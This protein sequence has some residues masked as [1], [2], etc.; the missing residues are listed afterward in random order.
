[1]GGDTFRRARRGEVL[2][3]WVGARGDP[4]RAGGS[5]VSAAGEAIVGPWEEFCAPPT[6]GLVVD[7]QGE[8]APGAAKGNGRGRREGTWCGR[9]K[10]HSPNTLEMVTANPELSNIFLH[11]G[12]GVEKNRESGRR[13]RKFGGR[14]L[15]KPGD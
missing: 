9:P 10:G 11:G 15:E 4:G 2:G 1:M 3:V 5:T 8:S 13:G 12:Q 7:L 6:P 14:S